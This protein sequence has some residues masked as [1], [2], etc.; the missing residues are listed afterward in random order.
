[1][2]LVLNRLLRHDPRS[3]LNVIQGRVRLLEDATDDSARRHNADVIGQV[4]EEL[5]RLSE[6]ARTT[7][8][9][10]V[11]PS[12]VDSGPVDV[13]AVARRAVDEFRERHPTVACH[14][15]ALE[16]ASVHAGYEVA[17]AVGELP[18]NAL[19]YAGPDPWIDVTVDR[20]GD[21]TEPRVVDDWPGIP[22]DE[23]EVLLGEREISQLHHSG[24]RGLWL[25]GWITNRYDGEFD[26]ES[27]DG[28]TVVLRFDSAAGR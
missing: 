24:G 19:A 26:I 2:L 9:L 16:S 21:A 4:S 28:T 12:E 15:T 22:A 27:G 17:A 23:R 13:A 14:L 7:E 11:P 10:I 1:M 6:K 8:Q 5:V 25:V 18:E 20:R 3:S